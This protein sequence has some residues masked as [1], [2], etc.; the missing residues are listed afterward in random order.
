M[1]D[2]LILPDSA[3]KPKG[4]TAA[5]WLN[6]AER[7]DLMSAVIATIL[8][9]LTQNPMIAPALGDEFAQEATNV[10]AR[11]RFLEGQFSTRVG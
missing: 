9:M 3:P 8:D 4:I 5:E 2:G 6:Y 10:A 11:L 7:V 1:S